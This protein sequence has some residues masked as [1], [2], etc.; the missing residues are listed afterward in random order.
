MSCGDGDDS[1]GAVWLDAFLGARRATHVSVRQRRISP[2]DFPL[3][4]RP[5]RARILRPR[6]QY[7]IVTGRGRGLHC[8]IGNGSLAEMHVVLEGMRWSPMDTLQ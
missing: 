1:G 7:S 4:M 5:A 6:C 3:G 2:S 8:L